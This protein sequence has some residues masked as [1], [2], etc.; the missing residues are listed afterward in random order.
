MARGI[1]RTGDYKNG[2]QLQGVPLNYGNPVTWT[3]NPQHFGN[4]IPATDGEGPG[5]NPVTWPTPNPAHFG[6]PVAANMQGAVTITPNGGSFV[7][8]QSVSLASAGADTIYYS[9]DGTTWTA[10]SS[11]FVIT[12]PCTVYA[13]AIKAGYYNSPTATAAFTAQVATPT[14]SPNGGT[15]S[16][17]T[18]VTISCGTSGA[19][20]FYSTDDSTW[21][22]YTSPVTVSTT[23]TLYAYATR[24][25]FVQS[26]TGSAA[27][28]LSVGPAFLG[29]VAAT[30]TVGAGTVTTGS[31]D[32][33]AATLVVVIVGG[34]SQDPTVSD[35]AGNGWTEIGTS[36]EGFFAHTRMYVSSLTY[37][38]AT[39]FTAHTAS[40]FGSLIAL[41]FSSAGAYE[42]STFAGT[43]DNSGGPV[44]VTVDPVAAHDLI[45]VGFN[46][47]QNS[48]SPALPAG[49]LSNVI[50]APGGAVGNGNSV[51][52][53]WA[54]VSSGG[55]QTPTWTWN[56]SDWYGAAAILGAAFA[57]A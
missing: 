56:T 21:V 30:D 13:Y 25:G 2:T 45:I 31:L 16:S 37:K 24:A 35:S 41:A 26:A 18:A 36:V 34:S 15:I 23:E 47:L 33:S 1:N 9:T 17:P 57:H 5:G 20:I 28:I 43:T 14:F 54:A 22:P 55:S 49:S 51:S 48:A 10:Y 19:A 8:S 12:N 46:A 29:S 6:N 44:G 40:G 42:A 39:T 52:V 7:G 3:P 4:P 11:A 53:Q 27:F 32:T 38:G 50:H